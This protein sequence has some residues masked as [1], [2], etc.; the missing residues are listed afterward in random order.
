MEDTHAVFAIFKS[1]ISP[2]DSKCFRSFSSE[3]FFGIFLI[4][5]LDEGASMVFQGSYNNFGNW[6]A[7]CG[8]SS[9]QIIYIS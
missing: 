8:R 9:K 4:H 2:L 1:V 7:G 3:I 6:L 5:S